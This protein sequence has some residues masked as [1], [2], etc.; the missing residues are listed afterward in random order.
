MA[1]DTVTHRLITQARLRLSAPEVVY[2]EME[3]YGQHL[4]ERSRWSYD[5]E[6]E[7]ALLERGDRLIDLALARNAVAEGVV[8]ALYTRAIVGT[9][10]PRHDKAIRL[11]CLA[12]PSA[13]GSFLFKPIP[14][15]E[16]SEIRRLA[17]HGDSDELGAIARNPERRGMLASIYER[18]GHFEGIPEGRWL[19]LV[20]NSVDNPALNTDNSN[21]DGPDFTAWDLQKA[22]VALLHTAPLERPWIYALHSLLLNLNPENVRAIESRAVFSELMARWEAAKAPKMFDKS[23]EEEGYYSRHTLVEEFRGVM[24]ALYG[25]IFED[26]KLQYM[27]TLD[28]EDF[29]LRCAYYG[30]GTL[31]PEQM[32]HAWH[33]DGSLFALTALFNNQLLLKADTRQQLEDCMPSE[34]QYL[35]ARRCAQLKGKY[36]WFD[37][38]PVTDDMKEELEPLTPPADAAMVDRLAAQVAAI[39]A[40]VAALSKQFWWGAIIL[41]GLV[42]WHR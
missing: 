42:L 30:S 27:G 22:I 11:A 29:V 40:Q 16:I 31:S 1:W 8:G 28:A 12:N 9:G 25:R 24:A 38:S 36:R 6:L 3:A 17:L 32:R 20:R 10:D 33:K 14:G 37:P 23:A 5:E 34:L 19:L 26:N 18:S 13:D 39:G 4:I 7:A 2:Q 21:A 15:A 41:G 35:Y